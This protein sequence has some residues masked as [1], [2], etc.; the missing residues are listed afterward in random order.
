MFFPSISQFPAGT[1]WNVY[2]MNRLIKWILW[3]SP[4]TTTCSG[5]HS[6]SVYLEWTTNRFMVEKTIHKTWVSQLE[7]IGGD[8]YPGES[9]NR[10]QQAPEITFLRSA[11][12]EL[13]AHWPSL[14]FLLLFS[15][16][17]F[18][19]NE[20]QAQNCQ[21]QYSPCLFL[22]VPLCLQSLFWSRDTAQWLHQG[23]GVQVQVGVSFFEEMYILR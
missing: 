21:V 11:Q 16:P 10:G 19:E 15:S 22:A 23:K 20:C 5:H 4:S 12:A 17:Y 8:H 9:K 7:T 13:G 6:N 1:S 3:I 2:W 14:S 18:Y